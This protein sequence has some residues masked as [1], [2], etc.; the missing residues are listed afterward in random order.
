MVLTVD[1]GNSR[2]KL[3]LIE[4]FNIL[5]SIIIDSKNHQNSDDMAN[6]ILEFKNHLLSDHIQSL[7]EIKKICICSV[8]PELT[9]NI[10]K[11]CKDIFETEIFEIK[12]DKNLGIK[13]GVDAP[14]TVGT[15]RICDC[16]YAA[17]K[18]DCPLIVVD[19]G[20]AIVVNV[21]IDNTFIGGSILP[22]LQISLD[23]LNSNASQINN[24]ELAQP[25][26]VVGTDTKTNIDSGIVIGC[27]GAIDKLISCIKKQYDYDF[28]TIITG[29][30]ANFVLPF[31]DNEYIF[32]DNLTNKGIYYLCLINS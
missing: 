6:K 25:K 30:S 3:R 18:Y 10:S 16:A 20:T 17:H 7:S 21:V 19:F 22:G 2:I 32:E 31:L 15:D 9:E 4:D 23:V 8:V 5:S 14:E 13:L 12:Y 29:S 11:M 1:I 26:E 24:T 27:A 28:K